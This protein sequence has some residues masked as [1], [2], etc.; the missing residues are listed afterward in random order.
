MKDL[1]LLSGEDIELAAGELQGVLRSMNISS[2]PVLFDGRS[3]F[4]K[5]SVPNTIVE[6]M[7]FAHFH[8]IISY[9]SERTEGIIGEAIDI[10]L[11]DA[12][13]SRTISIKILS[14]TGKDEFS[15][16]S[17]FE[18]FDKMSRERGFKV[19]HRDPE[20]KLFLNVGKYISSGMITL[21]A[22]RDNTE[23][24]R[25]S[26][27]PFNRP[28]VMEPKLARVMVNLSGL[29]PDSLILD[30]FLGP[31]GLAIEAG[32][33]G[34]EVIGIERDEAIH[35]GAL[36][37]IRA[38]SLEDS[39]RHFCGDSRKMDEMEWWDK[40]KSIDGIITDPPFG[41]SAPLMGED[42]SRLIVDVISK[43][44]VKMRKGAVIV[45]DTSREENLRQIDGFELIRTFGFRVH[46][47]LTRYIGILRKL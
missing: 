32:H 17:I 41:R 26:K 39:I 29:P 11:K 33:L 4:F 12:S 46:K 27:M 1:I 31:G 18:T 2:I 30:P 16:S 13:P 43:A 47:S 28:I 37:N 45:M 6:K 3:A 22:D 36:K 44:A 20:Q 7:G 8:G 10:G 40:V 34:Y 5:D 14:P 19:H 25:G 35:E 42:P 38:Q 21:E 15:R 24:R 23:E 9:I